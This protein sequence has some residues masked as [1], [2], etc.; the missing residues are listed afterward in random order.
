MKLRIRGDSLRLRLSQDEVARFGKS[1]HVEDAIRFGPGSTL[2]Y[3]L[4]MAKDVRQLAAD[5]RN[6]HLTVYVPKDLALQWAVSDM[7]GMDSACRFEDG[8]LLHILVEKD[9]QCLHARPGEDES[10]LYPHP[11]M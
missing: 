8:Q 1:G 3:G 6:D 9:Y 5:Y 7:V 10:N 4:K 11:A 2:L